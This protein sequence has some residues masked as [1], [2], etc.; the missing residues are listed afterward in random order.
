MKKHWLVGLFAFIGVLLLLCC[1]IEAWADTPLLKNQA[2][3]TL[4][5]PGMTCA[6]CPITIKKA[7]KAVKGVSKAA[8]DFQSR[9]A[10]VSYDKEQVSIKDLTAAT[11]NAGYPSTVKKGSL[12]KK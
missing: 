8:V 6:A 12:T 9:S 1:S 2:T 5:V 4:S 11:Q 7:L 10:T 3:V